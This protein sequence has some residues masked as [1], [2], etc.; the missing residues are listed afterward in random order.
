M[1]TKHSLL[2]AVFLLAQGWSVCSHAAQMNRNDEIRDNQREVQFDSDESDSDAFL[3]LD[4]EWENS[5]AVKK[6]KTVE[7]KQKNQHDK[8]LFRSLFKQYYKS[9]IKGELK[10]K[11]EKAIT[12]DPQ[13]V[14]HK[15]RK[16][17]EHR[18][19][20]DPRSTK[21]LKTYV[22]RSVSALPISDITNANQIVR[23]QPLHKT[24]LDFL[25]S[26][27]GLSMVLFGSAG[28]GKSSYG[29]FLEQDLWKKYK[30]QEMEFV[31]IFIPLAQFYH[32][33]NRKPIIEEFLSSEQGLSCKEIEAI[34]R[35]K[36]ELV[37]IL[38]GYEELGNQIILIHQ[39]SVDQSAAKKH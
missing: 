3:L 9:T 5:S 23:A 26:G 28:A 20:L 30:K 13:Q 18:I 12:I 7:N 39:W 38:D 37:V 21:V 34:K 27:D 10:P 33:K 16:N 32:R 35:K 25:E 17:Y 31:P 14:I 2:T 8:P 1:K 22:E 15:M 4:K 6:K 29:K 36:I 24:V 11:K 19:R